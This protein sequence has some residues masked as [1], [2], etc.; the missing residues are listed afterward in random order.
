MGT[1]EYLE[2]Y[3]RSLP[4]FFNE[5]KD[6]LFWAFACG[7]IDT[8]IH[9]YDIVD[10]CFNSTDVEWYD[11]NL[12]LSIA[13]R[14]KVRAADLFRL[15]YNYDLLDIRVSGTVQDDLETEAVCT[16]VQD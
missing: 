14:E 5:A 4:I 6:W 12:L 10:K 16:V 8:T 9:G 11:M 15:G 1:S 13:A 3:N 7:V 2:R